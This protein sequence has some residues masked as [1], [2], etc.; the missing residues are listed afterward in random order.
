MSA[1]DGDEGGAAGAGASRGGAGRR[2]RVLGW[3][4]GA[5]LVLLAVLAAV[6]FAA[7]GRAEEPVD[8]QTRSEVAQA[9]ADASAALLT[10]TPDTVASDQ[11]AAAERLTGD[12]RERYGQFTD[13]VVVPSA[14][15]DRITS[16]ATVTASGVSAVDGDEAQALVFLT[17]VTSS[18]ASPEPVTATVGARVDLQLVE[19]RWLVSGFDVT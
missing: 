4:L 15:A 7:V 9:A 12:F 13:T 18:N 8:P 11:Y 2:L 6:L 5:A 10:Y 1:R 3:S 17:Q 19:G 14:R 16:T